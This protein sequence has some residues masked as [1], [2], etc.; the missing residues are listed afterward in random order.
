MELKKNDKGQVIDKPYFREMFKDEMG[1]ADEILNIDTKLL[2]KYEGIL[3]SELLMYW[4]EYGLT[5]FSD[6]L[7]WFTN[8]ADYEELLR[9]YLVNNPLADRKDLHVVARSAFGKL[10]VWEKGKGEV[11]WVNLISNIISLNAV[12]GRQHLSLDDEEY[13]M[14][15]S[16]GIKK[17]KSLDIKDESKKPLFERA[18][19]KLGKLEANEMYGYKLNPA[20]GG[21]ESIRNLDKVNLFAYADIQLELEKPTLSIIDTENK[22]YTY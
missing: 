22:T 3:P 8:P 10:Y 12:T 13:E 18:L 11:V 6:G 16:I 20:L 21:K 19:K 2:E 17:P 7:F 5:S 9:S 4:K 1:E 15:R 14:N